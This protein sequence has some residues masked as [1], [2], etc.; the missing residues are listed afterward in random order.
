MTKKKVKELQKNMELKKKYFT[1]NELKNLMA[2][3]QSRDITDEE[4][5]ILWEMYYQR[6]GTASFGRCLHPYWLLEDM[7]EERLRESSE[8]EKDEVK[9]FKDKD[10]VEEFDGIQR[11]IPEIGIDFMCDKPQNCYSHISY[12]TSCRCIRENFATESQFLK[13]R[14]EQIKKLGKR[15]INLIPL[16]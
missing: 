4:S 6:W 9:Q 7:K 13:W 12:G 2:E 8:N 14:E 5:E 11:D 15:I 10:I 16:H 3:A 1:E